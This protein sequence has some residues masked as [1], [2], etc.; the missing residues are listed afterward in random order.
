MPTAIVGT[1]A[2]WQGF[3]TARRVVTKGPTWCK[4]VAK[5]T[6]QEP[7]QCEGDSTVLGAEFR[8]L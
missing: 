7:Q 8:L 2:L 6:Q 4:S 1:E 3:I 5:A